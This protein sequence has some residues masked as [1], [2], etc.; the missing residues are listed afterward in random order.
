MDKASQGKYSAR[1]NICFTSATKMLY[2]YAVSWEESIH[3]ATW[4][5]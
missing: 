1:S 4:E 3:V 5:A 2:Y